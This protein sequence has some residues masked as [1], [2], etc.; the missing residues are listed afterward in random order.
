MEPPL[1]R[2]NSSGRK[3]K[4]MTRNNSKSLLPP[5]SAHD[6]FYNSPRDKE[7]LTALTSSNKKALERSS[8]N[9]MNIEIFLSLYKEEILS[10]VRPFLAELE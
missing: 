2:F 1:D 6:V 8:S 10:F 7:L 9:A 3:E 5:K 4:Q